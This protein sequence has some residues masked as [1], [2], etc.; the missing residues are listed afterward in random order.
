MREAPDAECS[1]PVYNYK[2]LKE[3]GSP[4]GGVIDADSPKEA[5][6]KLRGKKLLVTDLAAVGGKGGGGRG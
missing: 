6:S 1:M 5:R 3:D 4:D 2:A